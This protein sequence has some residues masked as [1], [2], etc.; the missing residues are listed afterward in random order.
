MVEFGNIL[1]EGNVNAKE[2]Y[3]EAIEPRWFKFPSE[4]SIDPIKNFKDTKVKYPT[5]Y[6]G[7]ITRHIKIEG[8]T[9]KVQLI[10]YSDV[11]AL[12]KINSQQKSQILGFKIIIKYQDQILIGRRSPNL[13]HYPGYWSSPGGLVEYSDLNSSFHNALLRELEEET[14]IELENDLYIRIIAE[15]QDTGN[16][17][18]VVFTEL[19]KEAVVKP[20]E[21]WLGLGFYSKDTLRIKNRNEMTEELNWFLD[22]GFWTT[23]HNELS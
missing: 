10:K 6:D 5:I 9:F 21:E 22:S 19:Q 12:K 14:G 18:V 2:W 20:N 11:L 3:I 4:L 7:T 17:N 15:N 23:H 13:L 8:T 16:I 1:W